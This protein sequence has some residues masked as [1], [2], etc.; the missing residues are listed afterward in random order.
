MALQE[1]VDRGR[2]ARNPVVLTQAPKRD[3]THHRLGWTL[4]EA[5]AFLAGGSDEVIAGGRAFA[6][7]DAV[8]AGRNEYRL[9]TLNGSRGTVTVVD[10]SRRRL[11]VQTTEGRTVDLPTSYLA[12]GHLTHGYAATVH[13][14]QGATVDV[15]LL[16]IDDQSYR[17]AAYTGLSRGRLANRATSSATMPRPSKP[18]A[19][20]LTVSTATRRSV[21]QSGA[22]SRSGWPS[23]TTSSAPERRAMRNSAPGDP[24]LGI[25][26]EGGH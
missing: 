12:A 20:D 25:P 7:G 26:S 8:I 24:R 14:A 6:V 21:V 11:T 5:K 23:W 19:F 22:Q 2:L 9:G 17:E 15:A 3:R 4:D 10:C 18:T 13:K 16:L 1:A